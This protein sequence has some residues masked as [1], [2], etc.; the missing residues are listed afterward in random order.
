MLIFREKEVENKLF[1]FFLVKYFFFKEQLKVVSHFYKDISF[2]AIDTVFYLSYLF[3]NPYRICKKYLQK[4]RNPNIHV[5]GET[6]LTT[7]YKISRI[8]GIHPSD[9]VVELGSGRGRACFFLSLFIGAK[10][11]GVEEIPRF[12]KIA[13]KIQKVFKI[14]NLS[15]VCQDFL[16][17][18]FSKANVVYLYGSTLEDQKILTLCNKL[19]D[20]PKGAKVITVSFSLTDYEKENFKQIK[21]FSVTF[22]WGITQAYLSTKI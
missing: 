4:K 8:C 11:V 13:S 18:D 5:Y 2:F 20:L 12:I 7:L 19:Q 16:S 21:K 15:F 22:P 3:L 6:P 10:V 1:L 14:N 9:T 17:F